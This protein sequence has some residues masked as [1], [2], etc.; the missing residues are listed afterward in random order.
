MPRERNEKIYYSVAEAADKLLVPLGTMWRWVR[1]GEL[2]IT[3]LDVFRDGK[4]LYISQQSLRRVFN[5]QLAEDAHHYVPGPPTS[6][7]PG[8]DQPVQFYSCFISHSTKDRDFAER[9]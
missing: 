9:L 7:N 1:D 8:I 6:G 2:Q 3:N 5:S 4:A